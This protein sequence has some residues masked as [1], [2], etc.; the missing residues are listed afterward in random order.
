MASFALQLQVNYMYTVLRFYNYFRDT[1]FPRD[2][3]FYIASGINMKSKKT[4]LMLENSIQID[5]RTTK[6]MM[7]TFLSVE[8]ES[9]AALDRSIWT[10]SYS[11]LYVKLLEVVNGN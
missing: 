1:K 11:N 7:A 9:E 5:G 3:Q 8:M 2:G 4:S 10:Y 6:S